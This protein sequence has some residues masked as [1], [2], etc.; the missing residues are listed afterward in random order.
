MQE[1]DLLMSNPAILKDVNKH[2]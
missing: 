2:T 1:F